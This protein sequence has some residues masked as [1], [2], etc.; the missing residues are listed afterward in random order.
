MSVG[1]VAGLGVLRVGLVA[2]WFAG[3]CGFSWGWYNMVSCGGFGM[4]WLIMW[5]IWY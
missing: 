5:G 1:L 2:G 3:F 4:W